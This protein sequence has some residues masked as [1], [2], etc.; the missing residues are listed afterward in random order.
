MGFSSALEVNCVAGHFICGQLDMEGQNIWDHRSKV[1]GPADQGSQPSLLFKSLTCLF[2]LPENPWRGD[3]LRRSGKSEAW[4]PP[5]L[6]SNVSFGGLWP[7]MGIAWPYA[8]LYFHLPFFMNLR[9]T[10]YYIIYLFV[11]L[12]FCLVPF[13]TRL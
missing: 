6:C 5:V 8:L 11:L 4:L 7:S 9:D 12:F 2:W 3:H 13:P 1:M 10:Q